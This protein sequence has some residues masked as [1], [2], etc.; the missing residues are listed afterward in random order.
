MPSC[1]RS[2]RSWG[3]PATRRWHPMKPSIA[4]C[5]PACWGTSV[6][7]D[8]NEYRRGVKFYLFG[9]GPVQAAARLGMAARSP[10]PRAVAA[11]AAVI[12]RKVEAGRRHLDT[13][14]FSTHWKKKGRQGL[15]LRARDALWPY[16]RPREQGGL[17]GHRIHGGA[18]LFIDFGLGR[19]RLRQ[20]RPIRD[21]ETVGWCQAA[22]SCIVPGAGGSF[23]MN[24]RAA[25]LYD[26]RDPPRS[27]AP[28]IQSV[29][30]VPPS[31]TTP[32]ACT[33]LSGR[34][35]PAWTSP[36]I[37]EAGYPLNLTLDGQDA[38]CPTFRAGARG[39]WQ[40]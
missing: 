37:S 16:P 8:Q 22:D 28:R 39:G 23:A 40:G 9:I 12:E 10:R 27:C 31:A 6:T 1:R 19:G 7:R 36:S 35:H 15:C 3:C 34:P 11:G 4:P 21:H 14:P 30:R 25:N 26:A 32:S 13:Q 17:H 20:R 2:A 5:S 24:R 38:R 33:S 18:A 29:A